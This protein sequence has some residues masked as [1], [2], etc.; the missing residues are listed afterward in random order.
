MPTECF[1]A[2][3]IIAIWCPQ[4]RLWSVSLIHSKK[5]VMKNIHRRSTASKCCRKSKTRAFLLLGATQ[6]IWRLECV[7]EE[8]S[9]TQSLVLTPLWR[10]Q[11]QIKAT[12][13]SI[14]IHPSF[15]H[16]VNPS[17]YPWTTVTKCNKKRTHSPR[18]KRSCLCCRLREANPICPKT[19]T[20]LHSRVP[21]KLVIST[22]W[23]ILILKSRDTSSVAMHSNSPFSHFQIDVVASKLQHRERISFVVGW[24]SL[25]NETQRKKK[26]TRR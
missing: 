9:R 10:I 5:K 16:L 13:A 2:K 11:Y 18:S 1:R 8:H 26:I 7:H 3:P 24:W 19:R 23:F 22:S 15:S 14:S 17:F 12:N 25:H 20:S 21:N 4:W 6:L